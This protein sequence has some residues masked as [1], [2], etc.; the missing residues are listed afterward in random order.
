M[1][2]NWRT[3]KPWVMGTQG[4]ESSDGPKD[5]RNG[6]AW[7]R[8]GWVNRMMGHVEGGWSC[9]VQAC[10]HS[11]DLAGGQSFACRQPHAR[12]FRRRWLESKETCHVAALG[13]SSYYLVIA[14]PLARHNR[15]CRPMVVRCMLEYLI[16]VR[17]E[18]GQRVGQYELN[19]AVLFYLT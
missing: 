5:E 8:Q 11:P 10:F 4:Q 1:C 18:Q 16:M 6:E 13:N 14:L 17:T 12:I 15:S 3:C 19:T 9:L 2:H 7:C